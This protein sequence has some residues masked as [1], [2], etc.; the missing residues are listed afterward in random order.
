MKKVILFLLLT[1]FSGAQ[2]AAQVVKTPNAQKKWAWLDFQRPV[3]I[4]PLLAPNAASTFYCPMR[5]NTV[6]SWCASDV[7]WKGCS[8]GSRE[9]RRM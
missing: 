4:N 8:G 7:P 3:G 5:E 6:T 1:C 2:I 9:R